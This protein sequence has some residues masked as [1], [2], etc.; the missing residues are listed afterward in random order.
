MH[1][2]DIGDIN[3]KY[4]I[5]LLQIISKYIPEGKIILFGSRAKKTAHQGSDIDITIDCGQKI[6]DGRI[7]LLRLDIEEDLNIPIPV[8]LSDFYDLPKTFQDSIKQEG[9]IWRH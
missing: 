5:L 7:A 2:N 3:P 9:I 6:T 8:D 4:Y 1:R